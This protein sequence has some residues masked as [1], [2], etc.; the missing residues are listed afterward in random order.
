MQL[1]SL[2]GDKTP[3]GKSALDGRLRGKPHGKIIVIESVSKRFVDTGAEVKRTVSQCQYSANSYR[4]LRG[5]QHVS[6][7]R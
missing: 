3:G 5:M 7:R 2:L 6:D 4:R 1:K